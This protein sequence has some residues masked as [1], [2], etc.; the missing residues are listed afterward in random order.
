MAFS[1][2]LVEWSG[3]RPGYDPYGWLIWGYQ[4]LHLNLD[5]GGA[6]SW[7]P[8]T[9]VFTVPYS[10]FGHYALRLWMFTAVAVSLGAGIFGGRIAYRLTS[11]SPERRYA[12]S[13]RPRSPVSRC[14]GSRTTCTTSSACSPT[15]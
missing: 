12:P 5:L 11:P 14:S 1:V 9:W 3:T 6:P 15:R 8:L 4:T 7:K 2:A 10:L 13:S